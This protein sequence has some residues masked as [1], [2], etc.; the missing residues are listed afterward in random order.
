[1]TIEYTS[2]TYYDFDLFIHMIQ[3]KCNEFFHNRWPV[4]LL[5]IVD[6]AT[7]SGTLDRVCLGGGVNHKCESG[8]NKSRVFDLGLNV[9]VL[10]TSETCCSYNP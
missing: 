3:S 9:N 2:D 5:N 7:M 1:M 8:L 4:Q 6:D 10:H